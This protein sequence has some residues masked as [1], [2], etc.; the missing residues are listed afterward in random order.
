MI[1]VS[2][3][4][5]YEPFTAFSGKGHDLLQHHLRSQTNREAEQTVLELTRDDKNL[6]LTTGTPAFNRTTSTPTKKPS[7]APTD[8]TTTGTPTV[9]PPP[10]AIN[11][12]DLCLKWNL[13]ANDANYSRRIFWGSLIASETPLVLQSLASEIRGAI[14]TIV[15]VESNVT[16]NNYPRNVQY[17]AGSEKLKWLKQIFIGVNVRVVQFLGEKPSNMKALDFEGSMRERILPEWIALGMKKEDI[18]VVSDTDEFFSKSYLEALTRC[19]VPQFRLSQKC[20]NAK[21]VAKTIIYEG[22]FECQWP[23][24]RWFHPDALIGRCIEGIGKNSHEDLW[25][26]NDFRRRKGGHQGP[27]PNA[28]HLHN[29]FTDEKTIRHK[30]ATYGHPNPRA[31]TIPLSDIH[32]DFKF[33]IDCAKADIASHAGHPLK[34]QFALKHPLQARKQYETLQKLVVAPIKGDEQKVKKTRKRR[35]HFFPDLRN[36]P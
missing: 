19:Q 1:W 22:A 11:P 21:I 13:K 36:K 14:H 12:L 31:T 8:A 33:S 17:T 9:Y 6:A 18:G 27:S 35:S 20:S 29:F 30:Y 2:L 23:K 34:T 4:S 32:N 10:R 15:F 7:D 3:D 26:A 16:Q 5:I 25:S 24:R 28:F